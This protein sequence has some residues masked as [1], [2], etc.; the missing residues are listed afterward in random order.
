MKVARGSKRN[1]D[2]LRREAEM[3]EEGGKAE[4]IFTA[5]SFKAKNSEL[6]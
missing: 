6:G 4:G 2:S 1:I 3:L 5:K